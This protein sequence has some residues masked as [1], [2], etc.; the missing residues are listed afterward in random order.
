MGMSM[1]K[2]KC[3][4]SYDA[5]GSKAPCRKCNFWEACKFALPEKPKRQRK[6]KTEP[7]PEKVEIEESE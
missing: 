2:P 3:F 6:P 4:G 7:E 1:D 5:S